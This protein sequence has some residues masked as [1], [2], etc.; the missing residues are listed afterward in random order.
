MG[1]IT[2]EAIE[3][4]RAEAKANR[5]GEGTM[6]ED[7][8]LRGLPIPTRRSEQRVSDTEVLAAAVEKAGQEIREG[9]ESVANAISEL[10]GDAHQPHPALIAMLQH[11]EIIAEAIKTASERRGAWK[12]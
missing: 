3:Q 1:E 5:I 6:L 4:I 10:T 11:S 9:M 2:P 7:K 8:P 12:N